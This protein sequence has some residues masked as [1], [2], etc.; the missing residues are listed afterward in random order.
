M[1]EKSKLPQEIPYEFESKR[2]F[3]KRYE[4]GD[5]KDLLA[6]LERNDNREFLKEHVDEATQVIT[7]KDAKK[8]IK[9]LNDF[10]EKQEHFVMGIWLKETN[11]YIGGIWIQ[12]D[13]WENP[14]FN[15]GYFLDK[16]YTGKGLATEAA[17]RSVKFIFQDL[18]ATKI[19]IFTRDTNKRSYK[20]AERLGFTKEGHDRENIRY[21]G[22]MIGLFHYG[23]LRREY[24]GNPDYVKDKVK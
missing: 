13:K 2:L 20:L 24:L 1:T 17:K 14:S 6:L 12:P 3:I 21:E 19:R 16:G 7:L 11:T 8:R 9:Q 5:E 18:N 4:I 10:W 23:M 15:L 22:K